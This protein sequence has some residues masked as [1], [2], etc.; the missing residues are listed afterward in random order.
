MCLK[1]PFVLEINSCCKTKYRRI[2][3]LQVFLVCLDLHT[4]GLS[5]AESGLFMNLY[6]HGKIGKQI[7]L[8]VPL[9]VIQCWREKHLDTIS[10]TSK[11]HAGT[12]FHFCLT[13]LSPHWVTCLLD[14]TK[15]TMIS[16]FCVPVKCCRGLL[17]PVSLRSRP[18][19]CLSARPHVS[20]LVSI[21]VSAPCLNHPFWAMR[22]LNISGF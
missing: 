13:E 5:H 10:I 14:L 4:S 3:F 7:S 18:S 17:L 21:F 19:A 8:S 12:I 20:Q 22:T 2:M 9:T 6:L 11:V 15:G 16:H 1:W